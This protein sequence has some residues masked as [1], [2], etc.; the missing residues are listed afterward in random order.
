MSSRKGFRF[1]ALTAALILAAAFCISL[2]VCSQE[3]GNGRYN[4]L[5]EKYREETEKE[6]L[7]CVR[8]IL[9]EEG[10]SGC[11]LNLTF[12]RE[13]GSPRRY[14]LTVHHRRLERLDEDRRERICA[15]LTGV[16]I[17]ENG[18]AAVELIW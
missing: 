2:T 6:Y 8:R 12:R 15:R 1:A 18:P 9:A 3:P 5:T 4:G 13:A 11:G 16:S 7:E 14:S 10:Y 17:G